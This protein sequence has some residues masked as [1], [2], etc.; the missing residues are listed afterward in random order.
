MS[1]VPDL[2]PVAADSERFLVPR[3]KIKLQP[4]IHSA[5]WTSD[6][7]SSYQLNAKCQDFITRY[8]GQSLIRVITPDDPSMMHVNQRLLQL[9]FTVRIY[10]TC[11]LPLVQA[12]SQNYVTA[13]SS[14]NLSLAAPFFN[15]RLSSSGIYI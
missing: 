14:T 12:L 1:N 10:H 7:I 4:P 13:P 2:H 8:L 11:S 6:G 9:A 5:V 3:G 15:A